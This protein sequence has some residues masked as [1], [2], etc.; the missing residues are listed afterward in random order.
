MIRV[1]SLN[2]NLGQRNY[3]ISFTN[4]PFDFHHDKD[5]CCNRPDNPLF[6]QLNT[7]GAIIITTTENHNIEK[8]D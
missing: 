7:F 5:I 8:D 1:N 6:L 4:E 3:F 2:N